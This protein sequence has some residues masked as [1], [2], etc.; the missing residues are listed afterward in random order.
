MEEQDTMSIPNRGN[1]REVRHYKSSVSVA[2][3]VAVVAGLLIT[4]YP[5]F[6]R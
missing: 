1:Q 4:L 2:V 5:Y 6:T 3:A